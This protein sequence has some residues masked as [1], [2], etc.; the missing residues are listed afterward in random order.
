MA[1]NRASAKKTP[2]PAA[3]PARPGGRGSRPAPRARRGAGPW[4]D[5]SPRPGWNPTG[6][7]PGRPGRARRHRGARPPGRPDPLPPEAGDAPTPG[8]PG[9]RRG[10]RHRREHRD[11]PRAA[12]P[13]GPRRRARRRSAGRSPPLRRNLSP[14]ARN[15]RDRLPAAGVDAVAPVEGGDLPDAGLARPELAVPRPPAHPRADRLGIPPDIPLVEQG[16][17]QRLEPAGSRPTARSPAK[18]ASTSTTCRLAPASPDAG[19]RAHPAP[20]PPAPRRA[21]GRRPRRIRLQARRCSRAHRAVLPRVRP[22]PVHGL[23]PAAAGPRATRLRRLPA[24]HRPN[25]RSPVRSPRPRLPSGPGPRR[26][27]PRAHDLSRARVESRQPHGSGLGRPPGRPPSRRPRRSPGLAPH[28]LAGR[29][30]PRCS[31]RRRARP[32]SLAP[33]GRPFPP[34]RRGTR[35][36]SGA[37]RMPSTSLEWPRKGHNLGTRPVPGVARRPPRQRNRG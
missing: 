10:R 21:P 9:P 14:R 23:P 3:P 8:P 6:P 28:V 13:P 4:A 30:G 12:G 24:V 18:G 26:Q 27:S 5:R 36:G 15:A 7:G 17:V 19:L 25:P 35:W 20:S 2:K 16:R 31:P 11:P 32:R 33:R 1:T 34:P 37:E 29:S 22:P